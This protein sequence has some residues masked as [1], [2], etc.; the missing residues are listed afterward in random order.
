M[1]R[2]M[3]IPLLV[4][5]VSAL[6][7]AGEIPARNRSETLRDT[8]LLTAWQQLTLARNRILEWQYQKAAAPL[9]LAAD[10][11]GAYSRQEPGANGQMADYLRGQIADYARQTAKNQ[12]DAI[13]RI[14]LWQASIRGF[15][16]SC[17][18][19]PDPLVAFNPF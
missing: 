11:L 17:R 9:N 13:R 16:E 10:A 19:P 8:P 4:A 15:C 3:V 2:W 1:H 18:Y 5:G 14:E 7:P 6:S 12:I